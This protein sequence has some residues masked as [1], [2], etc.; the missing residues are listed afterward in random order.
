MRNLKKLESR[1]KTDNNLKEYEGYIEDLLSNESVQKMKEYR[2]HYFTTCF[3]HCL[4]VSYYS[5]MVCRYLGLDYVSAARGGLLHDLFL[6]D[7]RTT[8][9][10]NGKHAFRHPDI[11]FENAMK[12]FN[13]NEIEKD[14]IQKHMW[15]LTVKPPRYKESYVVCFV[16][17]YCASIEIGRRVGAHISPGLIKF[18]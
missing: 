12:I 8:K 1:L 6:Y 14:I 16:D 18:K 11:A 15:P 9:L 2:H 5:Y 7:W 10:D 4:N 13:L 17:K 3:E